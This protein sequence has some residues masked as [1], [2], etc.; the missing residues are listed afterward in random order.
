MKHT[1]EVD[2]YEVI[3]KTQ[4]RLRAQ[5]AIE[6][7]AVAGKF[8][9]DRF[10]S[11]GIVF[12]KTEGTRTTTLSIKRA[13]PKHYEAVQEEVSSSKSGEDYLPGEHDTE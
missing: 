13:G 4:S 12:K 2:V 10:N 1:Q 3:E 9:A 5:T 8:V 11:A 7:I 6:R